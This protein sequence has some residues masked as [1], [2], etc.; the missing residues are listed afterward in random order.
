[1]IG[2][3]AD[4]GFFLDDPV[5]RI[6]VDQERSR[7]GAFQTGI[8]LLFSVFFPAVSGAIAWIP[9]ESAEKKRRFR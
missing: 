6:F 5:Q 2:S 4:T 9:P 1:M 7:Y 8:L 3:A